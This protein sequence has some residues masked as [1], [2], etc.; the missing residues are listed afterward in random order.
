MDDTLCKNC[1]YWINPYG[2]CPF[3]NCEIQDGKEMY[4]DYSC[5]NGVEIEII[6]AT[7]TGQYTFV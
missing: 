2:W 1:T 3:G 4:E 7:D 6:H 5:E